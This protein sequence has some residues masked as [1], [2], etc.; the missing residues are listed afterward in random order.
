MLLADEP[1]RWADGQIR[2]RLR[3]YLDAVAPPLEHITSARALIFQGDAVLVQ[4]EAL[5]CRPA[6]RVADGHEIDSRWIPLDQ[7]PAF[8]LPEGQRQLLAAAVRR[9]SG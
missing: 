9:R 4:R 3:T 6:A 7:V 5:L 2:L 1:L 8:G